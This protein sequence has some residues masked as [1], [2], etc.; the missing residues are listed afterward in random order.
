MEKFFVC[1]EGDFF[2]LIAEREFDNSEEAI[3]FAT[4]KVYLNPA[5]RALIEDDL[6]QV[7]VA[8]WSYGFDTVRIIPKNT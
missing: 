8:E 6:R 7:Q 4:S 3:N 1:V 5:Q 2:P